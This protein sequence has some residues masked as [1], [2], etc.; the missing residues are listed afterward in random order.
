M[1]KIDDLYDI[2][3]AEI[4]EMQDVMNFIKINWSRNH[5][6][7]VNQDFF[8]Y[9]H[10]INDS[11]DFVIAVKKSTK[12]IVGILGI[13]RAS[14]CVENLDIWAGMWKVIDGEVPLLGFEIYK[15]ALRIYNARSISSVGDNPNTTVKILKALTKYKVVKMKHYYMLSPRK[16]YHIAKVVDRK[17][18]VK[19]EKSNEI[20]LT[21]INEFHEI[22]AQNFLWKNTSVVPYKDIWYVKHKYFEH[23]INHYKIW[24]LR[25]KNNLVAIMVGREQMYN[26]T[27]ALRII[28]YIGDYSKFGY[29]RWYFN[30]MLGQYEYID[31]YQYGFDEE[32]LSAAGFIERKEDDVNVIPNY[33]SPFVQEN[34]DIWCNSSDQSCVFFKGDGDQ[35]RPN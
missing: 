25:S 10:M 35:D 19:T 3:K 29:L 6:L 18:M 20:E 26:N 15:R 17:V 34:I 16:E 24:G 23:P 2:R 5:I 12:S 22:D 8:K 7:A 9:E 4:S 11:L 30:E 32:A 14:Q 1:R 27:L 28:D 31:F 33:F 13:L 21:L